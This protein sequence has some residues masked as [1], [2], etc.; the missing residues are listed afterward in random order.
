MAF[1]WLMKPVAPSAWRHRKPM[2]YAKMSVQNGY[3]GVYAYLGQYF[4]TAY[5]VNTNGTV[6]ATN[7]GVL[8]PYGDFFATEAGRAALVTMPDIDTGER[9]TN[10]VYC[11][12]LQVDKN[13]DG[14]M[15]ST[16]SGPDTTSQASPM[17][18]WINNGYT[19]AGTGGNL[20]H[21]LAVPPN[22]PEYQNYVQGKVTCPRDLENFFRLWIRG[23]PQLASA[24]GYSINLSMTALS[25][26]PAINIYTSSD[27]L[28]GTG[29]LTDTN[30]AADQSRITLDGIGNPEFGIA[31]STINTQQ[32]YTLPSDDFDFNY[33]Y[34]SRFLFE[35]AGVGLGQL[36]MT[37]SQSNNVLCQ[38]SVYLDLHDIKDLYERV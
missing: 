5:K 24:Q 22:H 18:C 25:G 12:S 29:Y 33:P 27:Y 37:I 19:V 6:T 23:V 17:V 36:T 9:G 14:V 11:V 28:G 31:L 2:G 3:S 34:H 10:I 4:D 21:D 35:G 15:D 16:F 1:T 20:D 26:N 30:V 7:T 32:S 38:A 13:H 8:S